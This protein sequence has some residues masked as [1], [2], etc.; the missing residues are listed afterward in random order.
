MKCWHQTN[1]SLWPGYLFKASYSLSL[2]RGSDGVPEVILC[3]LCPKAFLGFCLTQ[4]ELEAFMW[5]PV[6][7]LSYCSCS[8]KVVAMSLGFHATIHCTGILWKV[9]GDGEPLIHLSNS[10]W[11]MPCLLLLLL[12]QSLTRCFPES[13]RAPSLRSLSPTAGCR[14]KASS[15]L[16]PSHSAQYPRPHRPSLSHLEC[17]LWGSGAG[18]IVAL[19]PEEDVVLTLG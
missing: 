16:T 17:Q 1:F 3:L 8:S 5:P 9:N 2:Q 19:V 7:P 4:N 13:S 11:A 18:A 10:G 14:V 15:S 12:A 6:L